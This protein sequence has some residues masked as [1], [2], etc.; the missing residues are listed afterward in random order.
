MPVQCPKL[1]S[2]AI[3]SDDAKLAAALSCALAVPRTYLAVL[4]GPRTNRPDREAEVIRRKNALARAG[5]KRIILADLAPESETLMRDRLPARAAISASWDAVSRLFADRGRTQRP[6]L[7]WGADRLGPGLLKALYA[8][9]LIEF[10]EEPSPVEPVLGRS[11]HVVVCEAGEPL[12]EVIAANYAFALGAGLHLIDGTSEVEAESLLDL[13]YDIDARGRDPRDVRYRVATRFRAMCGDVPVPQGGSITFVTRRLPFGAAYPEVPTTH[14]FSYPDLGIAII[15][16][17]SA[18][19]KGTRGTNVAVVVDPGKVCAPEIE[20]A[21]RLLPERR[22]FLRGYSDGGAS[23]TAVKNM[24]DLFPYDLLIFA[25]H[26]CDASGYR[27]TYEY[28]DSEGIDRR[29]VVDIALGV[30]TTK[31]P[32]TLQVVQFLRFHSLD[33]VDLRDPEA[34]ADLYVG[35]A[36]K[37]FTEHFDRNDIEPV[38]KET[39]PRVMGSAALAMHD[40]NFLYVGLTIACNSNPIII[41]NACVSWHDLANRFTYAGT[42]AYVGTL[43][44]VADAEAEEVVVRLL[45]KYFGKPLPYATWAAQNDVYGAG[46]DR[47]PYVVTGVYPQRLRASREDVPTRLFHILSREYRHFRKRLAAEGS[48]ASDL[49]KK[50]KEQEEYYAQESAAMWEKWLKDRHRPDLTSFS[51]RQ[52][53]ADRRS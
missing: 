37:D 32:Q 38:I 53:R 17:F 43:F 13:L 41:N 30:G 39:I 18:E 11:N 44:S 3:I 48:N 10:G 46:G 1:A 24:V 2:V 6:A 28:R 45:S 31:D 27:W 34:K 49:I 51:S 12:S 20:A 26:C 52:T 25:T 7:R 29:L 35:T 42:R 14:L 21:K 15:N 22:I 16:G 36:I 9:Q 4:D 47:R 33:G 40:N 19:Q 8:G 23:V 5:V 50:L